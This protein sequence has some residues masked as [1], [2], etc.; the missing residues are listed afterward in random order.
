MKITKVAS[1]RSRGRPLMGDSEPVLF[2]S[3]GSLEHVAD[4]KVC[5]PSIE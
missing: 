3:V 5:D 1:G 4:A 2:S